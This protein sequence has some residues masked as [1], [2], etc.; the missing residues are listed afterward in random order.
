MVNFMSTQ[1]EIDGVFDKVVACNKK[2]ANLIAELVVS[3]AKENGLNDNTFQ[4]VLKLL[5]N[6]PADFKANILAEALV[7]VGR[8]LSQ[9]GNVKVRSDVRSDFFKHR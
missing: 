5:N 1:T 8:Q 7:I 3:K 4:E 2:S 9:G 6:Y